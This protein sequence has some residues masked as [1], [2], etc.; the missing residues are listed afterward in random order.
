[1]FFLEEWLLYH[2]NLGVDHI[3]LYDNTNSDD[4]FLSNSIKINGKSKYG[5]DISGLTSNYTDNDVVNITNNIVNKFNGRVTMKPWEFIYQGRSIYG[6]KEAFL[7]FMHNFGLNYDWA[8]NIDID[9]FVFSRR[10]LDLKEYLINAKLDCFVLKQRHFKNRFD[11]LPQN[12]LATSNYECVNEENYCAPKSI[13]R[14]SAFSFDV[15]LKNQL[16]FRTIH[17]MSIKTLGRDWAPFE[18][19]CFYHYNFNEAHRIND[20]QYNTR[21]PNRENYSLNLI[22]DSMKRYDSLFSNHEFLKY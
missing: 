11:G 8:I 6:Q 14:T 7:D 5:I 12:K 19:F 1:M 16:P 9:E 2:L 20:I 21:L 22:D 17:T 13:V 15:D 10:N 18:D 4:S 3:Y